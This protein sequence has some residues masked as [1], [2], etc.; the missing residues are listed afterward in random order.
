M[1][2]IF[3]ILCLGLFF[4]ACSG[5]GETKSENKAEQGKVSIKV[6]LSADYPPFE[7][8]N[9]KNEIDGFD[10]AL[11]RALGE[12]IGFDVSFQDISFDGL[13]PA[14]KAGKI[15][16][17]ASAMSATAER[18][19][20]IDFTDSYYT[21]ENLFLRKKG[22]NISQQDL[23]KSKI[24]AQLGSVQEMAASKINGA[25][26]VPSDTPLTAILNL[27]AGKVDAV[28]VDSSIGYGYLKTNDDI[29]EFLKLPDGSE[30]FS[31]AFDKGKQT[32][33]IAKI[34]AALGELK[35]SGEFDKILEKYNLK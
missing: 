28:I 31:I 9:E 19:T 21:T 10:V 18:K 16:A 14:L 27:V 1:R 35:S 29:E 13:I 12:K 7:F 22:T 6:G 20:S 25:T 30:G 26:V 34:N 15:D 32:E 23:A 33:L 2:K 24:G 3:A 4:A 5:G 8:R 11:L 17:I